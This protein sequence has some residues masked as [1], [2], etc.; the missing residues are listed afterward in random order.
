MGLIKDPIG[1]DLIVGPSI[2]TAND[3]DLISR[4]IANYKLTGKKLQKIERRKIVRPSMTLST[5]KPKTLA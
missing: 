5:P 4:A 2:L 1:I 3:R